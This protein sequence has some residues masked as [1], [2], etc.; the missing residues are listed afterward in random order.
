MK[1]LGIS[2]HSIK[3]AVINSLNLAAYY[4]S[5]TA[6]SNKKVLKSLKDK[7]KG[8]RCFVVCNGPSLRTEDLTKIHN[9]GDISIAMN[10][11]GRICKDTPWRPTFLNNT[12]ACNYLMK[13]KKDS[14]NIE[15]TYRIMTPKRYLN[16]FSRKGKLVFIRLDGDRKFLDNPI[17]DIDI[18][19]PFP[20]IG[21]TT[22]ECLEIAVYLG[23]SEIYIIGCDMSYKVN[24]NRDGSVTYNEAGRDH[25]YASEKEAAASTKLRPNP[26]WEM[27]IAYEAAA[28]ASLE[29][30]YNIKNATRGGKLEYFP[31]VD[32]D[33]LF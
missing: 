18:T 15:C 17:F 11:I 16:S 28:K 2:C 13:N 31:R 21:T 9:V 29:N 10:M 30:G 3:M 25:F 22:Y 24:L 20:S 1:I 5:G 23:C 14:E 27:E 26:T 32:F 33:S 19:K 4:L 8:K 6:V 12:D 7:Y